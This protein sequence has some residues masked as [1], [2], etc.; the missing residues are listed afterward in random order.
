MLT[1]HGGSPISWVVLWVVFGLFY[2]L[3]K[4]VVFFLFA[5]INT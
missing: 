4:Y 5:T 3:K 2:N 1:G